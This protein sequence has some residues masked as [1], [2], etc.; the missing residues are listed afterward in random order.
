MRFV[1]GKKI[2]IAPNNVFF[3]TILLYGK[4]MKPHLFHFPL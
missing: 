3:G 1:D 4:G 2:F